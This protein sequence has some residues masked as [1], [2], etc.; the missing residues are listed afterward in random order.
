M[1]KRT[2]ILFAFVPFLSFA[3]EDSALVSEIEA[4]QLG[5]NEFYKKAETSPLTK[6]ERKAFEHHNFFKIN[7]DYVVEARF[8]RIVEVDTVVMGTSGG[9]EKLYQPFAMVYFKIGG[10]E[11]ELTV[12]QSLKWREEYPESLFIPF[13]DAS[14]GD[15]SYGGGRYLDI[16]IPNSDSITLNFNLAYNPYCAY[17]T[18]YFC[19]IPPKNN[20]LAVEI[21]A[22]L[23]APSL[24]H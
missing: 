23:M 18:G 24:E 4:F 3:Q 13:R 16:V 15:E 21:R 14:S 11:C 7:L 12:Y 19:T 22:G 1:I 10:Q 17:T 20:T 8:E 5:Q 9:T 2:V 6:K